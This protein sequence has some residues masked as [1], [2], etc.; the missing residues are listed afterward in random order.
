VPRLAVLTVLALALAASPAAAA[1]VEPLKPCYVSAGE[2]DAERETVL[3]RGDG[4]AQVS[5]V[6]VLFD[7]VVMGGAMT[8]SVGEFEIQFPAP[9]QP[10]GQR[11]FR[12]TVRD[13]VNE[14]SQTARV[15]N[16]G[17]TVKPRRAS[18]D[19][20]VRFRGRGFTLDAPVY[21]HYLYDGAEQKTVRLA[22][23]SSGKCGT[24]TAKRRLIPVQNA[25]AGRWTL[26]VDQKRRYAP[27][28]D[29]VWVRRPIDVVQIRPALRRSPG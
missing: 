24:F 10:T 14:V 17:M 9:H 12:V 3:I 29:P 11:T 21:A 1:T 6:E 13:G 27:E 23:R 26:Q 15:T 2:A 18:P 20:K 8:G 22:R 4:F 7:G 19:R 28:P 16:L 25:R 5:A